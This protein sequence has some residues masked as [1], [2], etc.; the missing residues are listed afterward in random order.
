MALDHDVRHPVPRRSLLDRPQR[1]GFLPTL[2]F[3]NDHER[4]RLLFLPLFAAW[5]P[6]AFLVTY[7]TLRFALP[8][9]LP[10]G[11]G[12][13]YAIL[14]QGLVERHIRKRLEA[15]PPE[16]R[17]ARS[18]T[19]AAPR[20]SPALIPA[21]LAIWAGLMLV[22]LELGIPGVGVALGVLALV[23]VLGAALRRREQ[24]PLESGADASSRRL[25]AAG[26]GDAGD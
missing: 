15:M 18:T 21:A 24:R 22:F 2:W 7:I 14:A 16:A 11:L 5:L 13:V 23:L 19:H 9:W 12:I 17:L 20:T 4:Q 25:P 3:W 1:L 8:T 10:T 6:P 26:D